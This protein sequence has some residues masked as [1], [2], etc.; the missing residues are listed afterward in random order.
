MK[1]LAILVGMLCTQIALAADVKVEHAWM[2]A[3][4]PGQEVAGA[5][6]DISSATEATLVG[7][8]TPAAGTAQLHTMSMNGGVMEMRE[9]KEIALPAHKTVK[10]APGGLHIMLFDL[11]QAMKPGDVI[12]VTLDIATSARHHEK[13]EVN[14]EVR[15]LGGH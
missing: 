10:L 11:K 13:M 9:M 8:S 5:F 12:P 7:V 3:T 4:A 14:V 15:D 6:M 2:R 1:N